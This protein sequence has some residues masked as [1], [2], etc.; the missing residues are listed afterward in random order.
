MIALSGGKPLEVFGEWDGHALL[1]LSAVGEG[2][3]VEL[4][5]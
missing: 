1:P 5:S 3:F 4:T 2:R